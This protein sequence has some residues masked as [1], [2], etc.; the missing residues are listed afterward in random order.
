MTCFA[1]IR[2]GKTSAPLVPKK[3]V[4]PVK[5]EW[6]ALNCKSAFRLHG[7]TF[8]PKASVETAPM[9]AE[10]GFAIQG[11]PFKLPP[12]EPVSSVRGAACLPARMSA[13]T[14]HARA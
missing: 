8:S 13:K 11:R 6:A 9:E 5:L 12:A 7:L 14:G 2:A 3:R 4:Q 10:R 1:D